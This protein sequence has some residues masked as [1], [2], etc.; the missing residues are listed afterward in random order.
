MQ[1]PRGLIGLYLQNQK[2]HFIYKVQD[3]EYKDTY[4]YI[5]FIH[6]KT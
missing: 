6:V 4:W 3:E 2:N 1:I 5:D